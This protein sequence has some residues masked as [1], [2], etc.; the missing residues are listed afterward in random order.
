MKSAALFNKATG[1]PNPK[2]L[3]VGVYEYVVLVSDVNADDTGVVELAMFF[4]MYDRL[5]GTFT[6]SE[7]AESVVYDLDEVDPARIASFGALLSMPFQR[8]GQP[9]SDTKVRIG[10]DV[11]R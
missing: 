1:T 6:P 11:S 3:K 8:Q 2:K 10:S 9:P 4:T 5:L 7:R